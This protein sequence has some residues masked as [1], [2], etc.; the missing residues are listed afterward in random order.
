MI[1]DPELDA[2]CAAMARQAAAYLYVLKPASPALIKLVAVRALEMAELSRRHRL[3]S[4]ELKI[5]I[6]DQMFFPAAEPLSVKGG[7]SQFERL[8]FVSAKMAELCD[9]ARRAAKTELP[10]LIHGETGTGKE[11]LARAIHFNSARMRSPLHVQNCGGLSDDTLH[12]ELFGHVRGAFTGAIANRM[13][14][15][16]A[17]DGGTV[18]LD[19]ISEVSPRFQVSLLR[20]LQ[21]RE[22]KP[23]GSDK[24]QFA[25]VRIIAASN[26]PLAKLVERGEFRRDL[27][28]RLKGF[29]LLIPPL[30][31][32][33]E[34]VAPLAQFFVEKYAGV[35][36]R[37]VLGLTADALARLRAYAWPGNVR[38]LETEI[39]RMVAIAEQGGYI[40]AR[41][42]SQAIGEVD[43][44][45]AAAG[46]PAG[47]NLKDM[48]EAL[49]RQAVSAA[50]RRHQ[51][52][53]TRVANELG[54]SRVGLAN[55]I[56]RY[57]LEPR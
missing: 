34:D 52:N 4:R 27:F 43:I 15:F 2:A 44:A 3:L 18:F 56:K 22:I 1:A 28:Y 32:R 25:D 39:R 47:G 9:E 49:E 30:R 41:H 46:L 33:N 23:L 35:V 16:R 12:S 24:V 13:G 55:K 36:G 42:L 50:L 57:S 6:D 21:E 10:V 38:E 11:L 7:W 14:L 31:E 20:F 48:V 5:S 53:Q 37:R 45:D 8:V 40:S 26:R 54:L 51:W 19:E 29:E 17:A